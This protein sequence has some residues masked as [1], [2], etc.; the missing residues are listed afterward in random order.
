[1]QCSTKRKQKY[2]KCRMARTILQFFSG[3]D[4]IVKKM[5]TFHL[6]W[7]LLHI[8]YTALVLVNLKVI[9]NNIVLPQKI[10]HTHPLLNGPTIYFSWHCSLLYFSASLKHPLWE[11]KPLLSPLTSVCLEW[12]V[13]CSMY[14]NPIV[15]QSSKKVIWTFGGEQQRNFVE[16]KIQTWINFFFFFFF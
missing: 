13:H 8:L 11:F 4:S 9:L 6:S 2:F 7:H 12:A 15:H 3:A 14:T 10:T 1:M 5:Q 16:L